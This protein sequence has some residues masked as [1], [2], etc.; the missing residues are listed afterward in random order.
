MTGNKKVRTE[1]NY[2]SLN[3]TRGDSGN[4][5]ASWSAGYGRGG[6]GGD[7]RLLLAVLPAMTDQVFTEKKCIFHFVV[8]EIGEPASNIQYSVT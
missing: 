6:Q 1:D 3:L 2:F 5:F 7:G 8:C 4:G